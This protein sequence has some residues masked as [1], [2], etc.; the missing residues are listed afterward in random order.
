MANCSAT[1][2]VKLGEGRAVSLAHTESA[3]SSISVVIYPQAYLHV[4]HTNTL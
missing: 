3:Y 2:S 1:C 4:M